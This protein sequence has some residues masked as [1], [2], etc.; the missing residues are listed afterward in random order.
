MPKMSGKVQLPLLE[1]EN[2]VMLDEVRITSLAA[3]GER[4]VRLKMTV[5]SPVGLGMWA[6]KST[7]KALTGDAQKR[8]ELD[9]KNQDSIKF[10][11]PWMPLTLTLESELAGTS[12]CIEGACVVNAPDYSIGVEETVLTFWVEAVMD[13][14]DIERMVKLH[15]VD[16][17]RMTSEGVQSDLLSLSAAV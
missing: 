11:R 1:G 13:A 10:K 3:G 17:V 16:G 4:V 12:V 6:S 14:R 2:G 5:E 7:A 9:G 8:L 15:Q